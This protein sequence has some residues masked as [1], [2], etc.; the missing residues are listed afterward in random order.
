ML[1]LR[2]GN[3]AA[4]V[5]FEGIGF[6]FG[7]GRVTLTKASEDTRT[8]MPFVDDVDSPGVLLNVVKPRTTVWFSARGIQLARSCWR[9]HEPARWLCWSRAKDAV[10][11]PAPRGRGEGGC[12]PIDDE[13]GSRR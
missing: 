6:A 1:W 8:E 3:D 13:T 5:A 10:M 2:R 11:G 9:E 12:P 4:V 7:F